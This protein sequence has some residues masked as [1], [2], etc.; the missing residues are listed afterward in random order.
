M[1]VVDQDVEP[2]QV[3]EQVDLDFQQILQLIL[4]VDQER[5]EILVAQLRLSN[6]DILLQ[7]VVVEREGHMLEGQAQVLMEQ[8]EQI[9]FL[10]VKLQQV[11]D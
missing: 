4:K 6:Q 2:V 7:S 5:L 8:K 1:V 9:Q 10:V 3:V 11:V